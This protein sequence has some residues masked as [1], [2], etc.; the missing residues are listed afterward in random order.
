MTAAVARAAERLNAFDKTIS[1]HVQIESLAKRGNELE[2]RIADL[3]AQ[4]EGVERQ[5]R[6]EAR[7]TEN[8]P[9]AAVLTQ[10][11]SERQIAVDE[12]VQ[13]RHSA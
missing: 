4:C 5:V 11:K 10:R 13:R 3:N 6:S 1:L 9:F 2:K 8:T 12:I 7:G